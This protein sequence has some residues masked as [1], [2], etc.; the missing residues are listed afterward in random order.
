MELLQRLRDRPATEDRIADIRRDLQETMDANVQ[1]FRTDETCRKALSDIE[2]LKKRYETVA[3]QDKGLRYN[4]DL[5]EA[6]ELGFLLDLAEVVT[7]GALYRRESRGGHF[8]EDYEARDDVNFLH[9]TMAYRTL[10]GE[11]GTE[12]TE[13]RLGTKP[14]VITRYEPKERTF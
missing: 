7:V 13:I 6:V 11:E 3:V 14:V 5:L 9:H 8:R 12:G 10:P 4:L 2:A 1:V